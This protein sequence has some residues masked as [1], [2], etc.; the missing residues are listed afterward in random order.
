MPHKFR[1]PDFRK[2][3]LELRY[4]NGV[5][6]IY[7]TKEGLAGLADLI[8]HLIEHPGQGHIHLES[9]AYDILTNESEKGSVAIFSENETSG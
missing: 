5:V 9:K 8:N 4:E 7:G 2:G 3:K 6:G 1:Y